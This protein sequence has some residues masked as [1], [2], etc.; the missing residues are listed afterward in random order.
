L[1]F[2]W[3]QSPADPPSASDR[4]ADEAVS[5]ATDETDAS[6]ETGASAETDEFPETDASGRLRFSF[7]RVPWREVIRWIAEEADLALQFDDLPQGSFTYSDP[8]SFDHTEA[9]DR[10]NLFLLPQGYTLVRSGRLLSVINLANPRSLQQLDALAPLVTAAELDGRKDQ[11]V[12]KCLFPLNELEAGEAMDELQPLNLMKEPAVFSKTNQLMIVDTVAKLKN[13]K[14]ILD[15]FEPNSLANGTVMKSFALENAEAEDILSVARPHLGLATGEMIGIDVSLSADPLGKHLFVTGVEDKVKLI[16]DLVKALDRPTAGRSATGQNSELRMHPVAGGNVETV[17]NVLQTLLAGESLRLS[18]DEASESIVALTTPDLQDEIAMTV[19]RLQSSDATFEVIPLNSVDPIFAISLIEEMLALGE[20]SDEDEEAETPPKIDAD[21]G[22]MRLF[23]R[24]KPKQIEQI[25]QIVAGLDANDR[26]DTNDILVLPMSGRGA[27]DSLETA[28]KFWRKANPIVLFPSGRAAKSAPVER[29]IGDREPIDSEY[30]QETRNDVPR[31]TDVWDSDA[32]DSGGKVSDGDLD[33]VLVS[34]AAGDRE[35]PRFLTDNSRSQAPMIRCQMTSRGLLVQSDDPAALS[36]F[37]SH[38]QTVMGPV[39]KQPSPPTIFYLSYAKAND[40]LRMLAELLDGGEAAREGEAGTLVNGFVSGGGSYLGSIVMSR[41]GTMTMMA[42]TITVVADP[43]LNRLI[44]QGTSSDLDMIENYL[45][46]IDKDSSLTTDKTY[47]V[48]RVIELVHTEAEDVATAIR[49]AFAGRVAEGSLQAA[50]AGGKPGQSAAQTAASRSR[51]DDARKSSKANPKAAGGGEDVSTEP[52]MTVTVHQP[53]NSL[54]VTAP[55]EL[56]VQVVQ[57]A[58]SIDQRS[59][60]TV[61][62]MTP[63][64]AAL[65]AIMQPGFFGGTVTGGSS[66]SG[67]SSRSSSSRST[68][69]SRSSSSR[70][71][72]SSR[73]RR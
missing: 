27:M 64:S 5:V 28:A 1:S 35:S 58:E 43:R 16:E 32:W 41:E 22:N 21:P 25:K 37:K 8:N 71:D 49:E 55:D 30:L 44:A 29:A 51:D 10:I 19:A 69:S 23:V 61:E 73:D 2:A 17:Y 26:R 53:S 45:K 11:D 31:G 15:A 70:Y 4:P 57:L 7:D 33:D 9:I 48:A 72:S 24:G 6:A 60:Q 46:I 52:K 65:Q 54:I 42:G 62:V 40:A 50:G 13:A 67:S 66:R 59:E 12:V 38:L 39:D 63:S 34:T 68:S 36:S 47:G 56:F 14:M 18:I 3:S 20:L